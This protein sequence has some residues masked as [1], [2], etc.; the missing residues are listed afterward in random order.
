MDKIRLTLDKNMR[1]K[2]IDY[3]I[4]TTEMTD[5]IIKYYIKNYEEQILY[6][7]IDGLIEHLE[8]WGNDDLLDLGFDEVDIKTL[9]RNEF[10][11]DLCHE[12]PKMYNGYAISD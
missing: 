1:E 8:I 2:L 5:D 9:E 6:D 3:D 7:I 10:K 11:I 4:E 12:L